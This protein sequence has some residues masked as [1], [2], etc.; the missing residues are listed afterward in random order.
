MVVKQHEYEFSGPLGAFL[1]ML[2]LPS[3]CYAMITLCNVNG[4]NLKYAFPSR[5]P[6]VL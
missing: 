3:V 1:T 2:L 5:I 6:F 4:C